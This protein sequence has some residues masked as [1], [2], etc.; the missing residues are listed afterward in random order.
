MP[1]N[2]FFFNEDVSYSLKHKNAVRQWINAVVSKYG[3][4]TGNINF[5]FCSDEYLLQM[6]Q[7]HLDHDYYT[8]VITFD[9]SEDGAVSG[10]VFIS[11]DRIRDNALSNTTTVIDELHRVMIHGVLHLLGY[12]DKS[13]K[14]KALMT[15][16]EDE[17]LSLRSF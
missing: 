16:L 3:C 5:I 10:D 13:L 2:I 1:Q 17:S 4:I 6:N 9:Y 15:K 14:D 8:D 12:K 7:T 11:L